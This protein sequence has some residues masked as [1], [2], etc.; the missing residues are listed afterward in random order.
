MPSRSFV[1]RLSAD[2]PRVLASLVARPI[3]ELIPLGNARNHA[4]ALPPG[5]PVTVTTSVRL[6]LDATLGLA[7]W[8]SSR[9]HEAVPHVAARLIRDRAHF[10]DVLARMRAAGLRKLFVVGGDGPPV[11]DIADGLS[12]LRLLEDLDHWFDE[13]G[14]P[15]Y[16]EGHPKIADDVLMHDL[17]EK[18]RYVQAMT[19]QM[20]FNPGAVAAWIARIRAEGIM[21]PIHLG[22]AGAI[23]L[24]RLMTIAARIGVAD[25]TRYLLKHR[26]LFG[27]LMQRGSFGADAFLRDL[28]PALAARGADVRALHIFAMNQVEQT[29]AWQRRMMEELGESG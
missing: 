2:E 10:V 9:G 25:S 19:T 21:L 29:V 17:R 12:L 11:G 16:P 1:S 4:E 5:A 28:A 6:G 22:V 14:V 18:Q 24:R 26:S 15:A 8:L 20:S 23:E 7:E 27:H 3:Y 13:I